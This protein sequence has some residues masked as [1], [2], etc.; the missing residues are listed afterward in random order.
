MGIN[1][2]LVVQG[3]SRE[4]HMSTC[5]LTREH[6]AGLPDEQK[7]HRAGLRIYVRILDG[8]RAH[9]GISAI[10]SHAQS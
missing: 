2:M 1:S 9:T 3:F 6:Q 10:C 5:T 4:V 8:Q 7:T